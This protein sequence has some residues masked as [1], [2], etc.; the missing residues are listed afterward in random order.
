ACLYAPLAPVLLPA[1]GLLALLALGVSARAHLRPRSAA[2]PAYAREL[3][4]LL[5]RRARFAPDA[6]HGPGR[7]THVALWLAP[8]GRA[9]E[10]AP[11]AGLAEHAPLRA[12]GLAFR[13]GERLDAFRAL[14]REFA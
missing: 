9:R 4:V 2:R 6:G 8:D 13:A 3:G 5:E 10:L 7:V 1:L 14:P 12:A 11:A